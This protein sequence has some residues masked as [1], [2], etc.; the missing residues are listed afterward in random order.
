MQE[1]LE[2]TLARNASL[3]RN[4]VLLQALVDDGDDALAVQQGRND[5]QDVIVAQ[6]QDHIGALNVQ[7]EQDEVRL[8]GQQ[9]HIDALNAQHEQD[10]ARLNGQQRHVDAL[11]VQHEQDEARFNG[12]EQRLHVTVNRRTVAQRLAARLGRLVSAKRAEN[13][14]LRRAAREAVSSLQG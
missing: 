2:A 12:Q 6:Q 7:R 8:N 3:E 5:A 4:I 10:E 13:R 11:V 14:K 9:D 1:Q